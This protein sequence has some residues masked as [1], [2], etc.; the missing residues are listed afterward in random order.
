[1]R[2]HVNLVMNGTQK[3]RLL[4]AVAVLAVC[5]GTNL[6]SAQ[7][8]QVSL[9]SDKATYVAGEPIKVSF[10]ALWLGSGDG[11]LFVNSVAFPELEIAYLNSLPVEMTVVGNFVVRPEPSRH[12]RR[13]FA[14][15]MKLESQWAIINDPAG[16]KFTNGSIGFYS[17][18]TAGTYVIRA[19]FKNSPTWPLYK[20]QDS[21]VRS[22]ALVVEISEPMA[23]SRSEN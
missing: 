10:E 22:N 21:D 11:Y 2:C 1:M 4:F 3:G 7:D 20:G 15:T 9:R 12:E 18:K 6:S 13:V 17:L 19:V 5:V 16:T 14:P 8:I 23:E